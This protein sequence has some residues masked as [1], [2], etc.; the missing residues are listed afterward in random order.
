[1]ANEKDYIASRVAH[2]LDLT[3]PAIS[4]HTACS[5]SLVAIA[6]AFR[7]L[8]L[9]ECDLAIAGGVSITVPV[10]SGHLYNEGSMLSNDGRTRTFDASAQGTVFSDG[11]GAVVLRRLKTR[12]PMETLFMR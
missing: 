10:N 3:G 11:C 8:Q 5:T 6:Q 9:G 7:S 12:S 4:V 2:R 1:M